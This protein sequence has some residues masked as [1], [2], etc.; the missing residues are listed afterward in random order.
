[1]VS[2]V[3]KIRKTSVQFLLTLLVFNSAVCACANATSEMDEADPHAHH[4]QQA[5]TDTRENK[6][7]CH[8]ENCHGTCSQVLAQ[9]PGSIAALIPSLKF[10]PDF[11]LDGDI[12]EA[13]PLFVVSTPKRLNNVHPPNYGY[14]TLPDTPVTRKDCLLA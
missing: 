4:L 10:E 1:M 7:D 6:S 13:D 11:E 5:L 8:G 3:M 2:L 9:K 14:L 12:H